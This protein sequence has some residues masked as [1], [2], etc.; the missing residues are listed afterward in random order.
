M[1]RHLTSGFMSGGGCW[2]LRDNERAR[3][4]Y[5]TLGDSSSG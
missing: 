4:F 1:A 5:E 3:R 2:A